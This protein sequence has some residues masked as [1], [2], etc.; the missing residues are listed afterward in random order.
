MKKNEMTNLSKILSKLSTFFSNRKGLLIFI[1]IILV[2]LNFILS[3]VSNNWVTQSNL[4]LHLG[5]VIG[6]LGLLIA[7]AL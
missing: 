4:L 3:L 1:A 2:I 6:F 7:W 5:I